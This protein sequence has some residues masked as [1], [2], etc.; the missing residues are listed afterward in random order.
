MVIWIINNVRYL[1]GWKRF[2][3]DQK[4]IS[5]SAAIN[6]L[7]STTANFIYNNTCCN[8]FANDNQ[9]PFQ[10]EPLSQKRQTECDKNKTFSIS[11]N[12]GNFNGLCNSRFISYDQSIENRSKATLRHVYATRNQI[13]CVTYF[14]TTPNVLTA[15]L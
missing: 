5:Q 1:N 6:R 3:I 2:K 7:F 13:S 11:T 15:K 12:Y 14:L 4:Q 9:N 8:P 10:P